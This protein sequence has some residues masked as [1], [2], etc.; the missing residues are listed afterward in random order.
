MSKLWFY[1][2]VASA[3]VAY[4]LLAMATRWWPTLSQDYWAFT[5][6]WPT[7]H[8]VLGFLMCH[9]VGLGPPRRRAGR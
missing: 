3:I 9:L 8:F 4:E 1:V 2:P 7:M 5:I 6:D